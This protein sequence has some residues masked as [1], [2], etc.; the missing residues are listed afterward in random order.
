MIRIFIALKIEPG[1]ILLDSLSFLKHELRNDSINWTKPKNI[2]ITLA[3]L[4]D[5]HENKILPLSEMLAEKCNGF[6]PFNLNLKGTGVFRSYNDPRIIWIGIMPSEK[7]IKLN[8]EIKDGLRNIGIKTEDRPFS[9][10]ITVGR[11]K[12][13]GDPQTLKSIIDLY[14]NTLFQMVHVDEVILFES[15][16][17]QTGP[18]YKTMNC[19][20]FNNKI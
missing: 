14:Q 20:S 17:Q 12:R 8:S 13:T 9:P 4:G 7:L 16:L 10:H 19:Y 3:F 15:I 11:I 18:I 2:H 1:E 5:T 6:E